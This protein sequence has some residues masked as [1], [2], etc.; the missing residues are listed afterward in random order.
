VPEI[1]ATVWNAV[2]TAIVTSIAG[3]LISWI[4]GWLPA[5]WETLTAAAAWAW[6]LL[7]YSMSVPLAILAVLALPWLLLSAVWI[8]KLLEKKQPRSDLAAPAEPPLGELELQLLRLL[9]RADGLLVQFDDAASRLQTSRLLLQRAC[10]SLT[11]RGYIQPH[12]HVV[13]GTSIGLTRAG[14]EFVI[15]QGFPLGGLRD[16]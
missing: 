10:E 11:E 6:A 12:H 16:W 13:R 5:L 14:T 1:S 15:R 9:A 2:V 7:T 3:G 8:G 4:A